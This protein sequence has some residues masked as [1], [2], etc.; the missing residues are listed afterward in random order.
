MKWWMGIHLLVGG[1]FGNTGAAGNTNLNAAVYERRGQ[2]VLV[3]KAK[4]CQK[5]DICCPLEVHE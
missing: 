2:I 3:K 5:D 1:C 4:F